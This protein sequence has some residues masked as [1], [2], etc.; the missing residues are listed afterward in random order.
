MDPN[1]L[2][3]LALKMYRR[4]LIPPCVSPSPGLP[5]RIDVSARTVYSPAM[6]EPPST[7]GG[8]QKSATA[9]PALNKDT[10]APQFDFDSVKRIFKRLGPMG[11]LTLVAASLPAIGGFLLL[12]T[13]GWTGAW[14]RDHG[15]LGIGLFITGFAVLAG[16]ALLP[17][18]AQS[19]LAGWAF[20]FATGSMSAM[21]GIF[22]ASVIAYLIA[23]R[24]AG[25]R[26]VRLIEEQ[27]KWRAVYD[28]LVRSGPGR[29]LLTVT[30]LRIPHNSPFAITN[31]VM[32]SCRVPLWIYALGTV[33][34]IAPRTLLAVYLGARAQTTD[35]AMP[36]E[37][38][39]YIVWVVGALLAVAVIGT[40]A[41]HAIKR[42]TAG[43]ASD[44]GPSPAP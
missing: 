4:A 25:D 5:V 14:L 23:K 2:G 13:M 26:V 10:T 7:P 22:G 20:G 16:L 11:P 33:V 42:V 19:V 28:A 41:N 38:W 3:I 32:A 34:G 24:A 6:I 27:P 17:T 35:F 12:G 36:S 44:G 15:N 30:L 1:E 29:A 21:A 37:K 40:I 9:E 43:M 18:Y 39:L 31:L 8:P